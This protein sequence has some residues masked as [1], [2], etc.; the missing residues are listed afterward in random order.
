MN[1][2]AVEILNEIPKVENNEYI[3]AS[4]VNEGEPIREIK[5]PFKKALEKAGI[6]DFRF[7]DLRHT[8]AS[9]FQMATNDQRGLS[10]LLGHKTT[11]MTRRYTHLSLKH[12]KEGVDALCARLSKTAT[13]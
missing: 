2:R 8:F 5:K 12:K 4:P 3:F 1:D 11:D 6:D 9:H 13:C 10:E 7:H